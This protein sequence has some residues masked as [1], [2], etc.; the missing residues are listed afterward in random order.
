MSVDSPLTSRELHESLHEAF[1]DHARDDDR[2]FVELNTKVDEVKADV[3]HLTALLVGDGTAK[4]AGI[5]GRLGILEAIVYA[6]HSKVF[7]IASILIPALLA[8]GVYL[9]NKVYSNSEVINSIPSVARQLRDD[10]NKR[11]EPRSH[12]EPV[13]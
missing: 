13:Q 12:Q 1:A 7:A 11:F 5:I 3:A 2:H 8:A 6:F 4:G 10:N 9:F